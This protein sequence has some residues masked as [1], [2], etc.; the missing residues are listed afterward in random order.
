MDGKLIK[1]SNNENKLRSK[2]VEGEFQNLPEVGHSFHIIGESLTEGIPYRIV[3]TSIVKE[4]EKIEK[5][6]KIVTMNSV[7]ELELTIN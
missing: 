3:S 7:Y 1:I 5:G 4:I 2:S 6:Y